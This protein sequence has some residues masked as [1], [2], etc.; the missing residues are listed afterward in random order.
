MIQNRFEFRENFRI[1]RRGQLNNLNWMSVARDVEKRIQRC[2]L[3]CRGALISNFNNR[4]VS[5]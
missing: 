1:F 5:Q 3:Q 4:K 2:E